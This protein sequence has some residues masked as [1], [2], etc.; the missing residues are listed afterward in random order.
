M[1][2]Y[3]VVLAVLASALLNSSANASLSVG[4]RIRFT[5]QVGSTGG[6][7][8]GVHLKDQV[9]PFSGNTESA[10][11]FRT[12]C[13]EKNEF[14]DFHQN[15]FIIESIS[16]AAE[17]G[18]VG[19]PSPDPIS[20]QTAWLYY[21][22]VKGTLSGYLGNNVASADALQKAIWGFEDELNLSEMAA[23]SNNPF[24]LAADAALA[25]VDPLVQANVDAAVASVRVLNIVWASD[26]HGFDGVYEGPKPGTLTS[27][28]R[29]QSVLYLDSTAIVPEASTIAVWSILSALGMGLAYCRKANKSA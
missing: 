10:E 11:L 26:R 22:F 7:E 2:N 28:D 17:N 14:I 29:A 9:N 27:G 12:F 4:D 24:V 25:S 13:L 8:F 15:G 3:V 5:D 6:G 21:N 23:W 18:G 16:T 19:G 20:A 1:K